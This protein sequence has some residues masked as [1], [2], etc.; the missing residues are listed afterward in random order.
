MGCELSKLICRR[1]LHWWGHICCPIK[2][3]S[4]DKVFSSFSIKSSG[5][6]INNTQYIWL[7][8]SNWT[9]SFS[10][11]SAFRSTVCLLHLCTMNPRQGCIPVI[12]MGPW[13]TQPEHPKGVK[14]EVKRPKGPPAS[15]WGPQCPLTSSILY[16]SKWFNEFVRQR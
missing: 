13:V 6:Q 5:P 7:F 4:A 2:G 8:S 1:R 14:D 3:N 10:L 9:A 16:V 15:S 12:W 11:N